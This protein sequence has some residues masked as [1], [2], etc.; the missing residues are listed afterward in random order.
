M[1]IPIDRTVRLH[2]VNTAFDLLAGRAVT[3]KIVLDLQG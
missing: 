3:G 2:D 1:R